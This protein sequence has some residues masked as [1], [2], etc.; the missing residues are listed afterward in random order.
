MRIP[1]LILLALSFGSPIHAAAKHK[2][3]FFST[4]GIEGYA[5]PMWPKTAD[6]IHVT[7]C[8]EGSPA[9]GKLRTGDIIVGIG[10][11]KF[12]THPLGAIATILDEAEAA[13]GK[14]ALLLDGGKQVTLQ[15][16]K[17][18]AYSP[19]APYNCPKTDAI[20]EQAAEQLMKEEGLGST[21]TRTGLLGLM[22]TG[23]KKH[24]DVVA[25]IIRNSD[26]LRVDSKVID[27][28]LKTG[29]PDLGSTGWTW[30]YNLIAL[31]EYYLLTK[32]ET[33]LPA[34]RTYA[35]GL[36]RGQD[37]VGLWGHRMA[38][39]ARGGR[40][41]GY[42]IMNQCSLS[43][44][45]GMLLARKCGIKDPVLD[46]A[47]G[48]THAYVAD[49][50]NRGGFPYGVH[51]PT[52][53]QFNNNGSS[54]AAAICMALMGDKEGASCFSK[55]CVP[56]HNNLTLGHASP[57]F[58]PLWTPLG[59]SLSGPEVTQEFFKRSLWY[60]NMKRH[61]KGGFPG[62]DQAGF[63]AGQALLAYCLPRKVLYI[64]G[65][66][67]DESIWIKG[68]EADR[69]IAMNLVDAKGRSNEALFQMLHDPIIQ[70]RTKAAAEMS[71]RL[72]F[73][74]G[75]KLGEDPFTPTLLGSIRNGSE[76]E[77]IMALRVLG[78]IHRGYS[79]HFA[80][81]FGEVMKLKDEALAVRVEAAS[82]FRNC[83]VAAFPYYNDILKLILGKRTAPDPFGHID[84]KLAMSL[85]GIAAQLK[86]AEKEGL[87][88]EK[89]L[90]YK[91]AD[92]FLDH[93]RQEVRGVGIRLL[94]GI[95]LEDFHI[96]GGKLMHV[97]NDEDRGYHSYS[98][99]LN[100]DGI[101]ILAELNIKEGLGLLE[102]GIFHGD[103]KWGF[104]YD[105]LIK[106]LPKYGA[107]AKPYI[108]IFEAH[109]NINKEGDR[110]T[111]A[112]RQAVQT[113]REDDNPRKLITADEAIRRGERK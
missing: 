111:P 93:P 91:V 8:E 37:A 13:D 20:I 27:Q 86:P 55:I 24:L 75:R 87:K 82:A 52:E 96:V 34:I 51:G 113:I 22:A 31:G 44:F 80:D 25:E 64:T 63:F 3:L 21:P 101:E 53:D 77:K 50:I 65:R 89:E 81:T 73:D 59:A 56:T 28:Y 104:K 71:G 100:A 9:F 76:L 40:S 102:D 78:G 90:L 10:N 67:A 36:A 38:T 92:R 17:L 41:P 112:W 98:K 69:L 99:V 2:P 72:T 79:A 109:P 103:G 49:H 42:G 58:N 97:L 54:A 29:Q 60:F 14:L 33:V 66:E 105:A 35:L 70:E 43:N 16:A 12:T 57:F 32:D 30:G 15:L 95:S 48:T 47:I 19:T 61:W 5:L 106:A 84:R 23:D 74:W 45:M 46:K 107:N 62:K 1:N 39:E 110:F 108:A 18:G 7:G 4:T 68:E 85:E 11:E 83:G 94:D 6:T 88:P 26:M